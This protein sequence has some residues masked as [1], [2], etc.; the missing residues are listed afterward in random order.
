[1][2]FGFIGAGTVAQTI[3]RHVLPFGHEVLLSNSRG[4]GTLVDIVGTPGPGA[5]AGTPQQ[6]ANQD[7][8]VLSGEWANV[9]KALASVADWSGRTLIDATNRINRCDPRDLGNV[10]GQTSSEI[11]ANHASGAK[12]LK[13]FNTVPM[14]WI[15]DESPS[16]PKT[17][18]FVSGDDANA[19]SA[20]IEV[21]EEVGFAAVDVG[22]LAI[23]GSLQQVGGPLAAL[24]LVL[25]DRFVL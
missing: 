21:L 7:L 20:L 4:P 8:V 11:V 17:V 12:L 1:M 3:A 9:P 18:L 25:M 15:A 24:N 16:K 14:V 10:A 23:G 2:K 19:K 22:S 5:S 6:A 13:A